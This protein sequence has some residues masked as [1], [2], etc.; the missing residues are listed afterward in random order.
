MLMNFLYDLE[1]PSFITNLYNNRRVGKHLLQ[2]NRFKTSLIIKVY[3]QMSVRALSNACSDSIIEH[4]LL[5][6]HV[7]Y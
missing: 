5:L 2:Y 4:E 3:R 7:R 1:S 6:D